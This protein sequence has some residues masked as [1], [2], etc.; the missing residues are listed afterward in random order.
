MSEFGFVE[1]GRRFSY[2]DPTNNSK[3]T[4]GSI[5]PL[6]ECPDEHKDKYEEDVWVMGDREPVR[7]FGSEYHAVWDDDPR[8]EQ[9]YKD[10]EGEDVATEV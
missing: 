2:S 10:L 9:Y 8:I 5:H 6:V 4:V 7:V 3:L 1:L